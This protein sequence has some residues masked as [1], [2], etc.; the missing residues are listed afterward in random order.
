MGWKQTRPSGDSDCGGRSGRT[1]SHLHLPPPS[2]RPRLRLTPIS[3]A[4]FRRHQMLNQ[5]GRFGVQKELLSGTCKD[6]ARPLNAST[7]CSVLSG[8]PLACREEDSG[9]RPAQGSRLEQKWG[10]GAGR[11]ALLITPRR[12]ACSKAATGILTSPET[13]QETD[14]CHPK[15]AARETAVQGTFS[16]RSIFFLNY[17]LP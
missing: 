5:R 7:G 10:G 17:F 3:S 12:P 14:S 8:R 9:T 2:P 11:G 13:L 15:R 1:C 6:T 16:L 4:L